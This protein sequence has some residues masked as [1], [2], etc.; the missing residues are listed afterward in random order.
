MQ[1]TRLNIVFVVSLLSKALVNL[2]DE[3]IQHVKHIIRYLQG[4]TKHRL[5]YR[6]NTDGKF[7]L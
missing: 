3:Y 7:N 2:S 4:T 5:V 6:F 1:G